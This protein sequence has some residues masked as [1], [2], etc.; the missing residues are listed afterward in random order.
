MP[1]F[2][3]I[4][5]AECKACR[6]FPHRLITDFNFEYVGWCS[7]NEIAVTDLKCSKLD[8]TP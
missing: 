2:K 1:K 4:E 8:Y 3:Y 5:R 6:N 7:F